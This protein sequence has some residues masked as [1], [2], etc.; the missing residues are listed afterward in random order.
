MRK[1][2][3]KAPTTDPKLEQW[4]SF[5]KFHDKDG[6][7]ELQAHE[8]KGLHD[9]LIKNGIPVNSDV[10]ATFY[11]IDTDKTGTITFDEFCDYLVKLRARVK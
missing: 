7:G 10:L 9:G 6:S 8:F 4:R 3:P 1:S 11:E 5:F 2:A